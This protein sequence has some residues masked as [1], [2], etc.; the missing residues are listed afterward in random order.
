MNAS[1]AQHSPQLDY[2]D[3]QPQPFLR[4]EETREGGQL[5]D[6]GLICSGASQPQMQEE[7]QALLQLYLYGMEGRGAGESGSCSCN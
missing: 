1:L 5:A 7:L 3:R 4:G 2:K 6:T